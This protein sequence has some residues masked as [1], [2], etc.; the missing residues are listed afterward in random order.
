MLLLGGQWWLVARSI[1]TLLEEQ[2]SARLA[3][4]AESLLA[5]LSF[6]VDGTPTIDARRVALVYE[7]P[8]SGHYY[9]VRSNR[10]QTT[11]R[12]IWD[13]EL[14]VPDAAPG[15]HL[16][17]RLPGPQNQQLFVLVGGYGKL[18]RN[19]TIAAA[20]DLS[21]LD[22]AVARFELTYGVVS[23]LVL[24]ALL[25]VQ[26]IIVRGGLRPLD[27]IREEM[28]RL[29]RGATERV[30]VIAPSEIV[31]LVAE[32]NRLLTALANRTRRSRLALGNLAHALKTQLAVL[33][34]VAARPELHRLPELRRA[35]EEP[36]ES[37][38]RIVERELRR[39]RLSGS[40]PP[41]LRLPLREEV[42][43]LS[44]TLR[45]LYAE[46]T[47][48]ISVQIPQDAG[49]EGDREDFLEL[50]GNLLDNACKWCSSRVS[51]T[52]AAQTG[53]ELVVEDDGPGC[54]DQQL[55]ELTR[56]GF[57]ADETKPG[58]GLGLAIVKDVVDSYG[59]SLSFGRSAGLGGLRVEVRLPDASTRSAES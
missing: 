52:I 32:L 25:L 38:R 50:L 10:S 16:K 11:S 12:S 35:L 8:F 17:I 46:K 20:E 24:C 15:Q 58:S 14:A 53:L 42:A 30:S 4:D 40:G 47:L 5:G 23:T 34:Q 33:S 39:A 7:R 59:G 43:A 19:V 2:L 26:W 54:S 29:E 49:F 18:G 56:R 41:G 27:A 22:Q 37:S 51:L 55:E 36:I 44:A 28:S 3:H 57:R 9:V 31:P 13:R 45:Q 1:E 21:G 48:A 6:A